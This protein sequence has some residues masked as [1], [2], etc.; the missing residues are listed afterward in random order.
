M[1][2][3]TLDCYGKLADPTSWVVRINWNDHTRKL[4]DIGTATLNLD[5]LVE[6]VCSAA[7]PKS[8]YCIKTLTAV[9]NSLNGVV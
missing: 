9:C 4:Q 2:L 7:F 5:S 3:T 1:S 6:F 8:K